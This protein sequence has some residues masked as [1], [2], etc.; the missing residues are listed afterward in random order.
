MAAEALPPGRQCAR[1]DAML[2]TFLQLASELLF[3]LLDA[4]EDM[5]LSAY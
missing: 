5:H 3:S 2:S 1:E 4:A